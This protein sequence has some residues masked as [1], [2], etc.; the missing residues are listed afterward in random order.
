M[1]LQIIKGQGPSL[2]GRNWLRKIKLNWCSIKKISCDLQLDNVL[3]KHQSVFKDELGT[4]Q[5][6]MAKLFVK[7]DSMPIFFKP[8]PVPHALK[9]AFEQELDRL[10]GMGVIEKVRYSEWAAPIV[11]VVKPDNLIKVC[12]HCKVNVNS[13]LEVDQHPLPNLKELFVTL[14]GGEKYSKLDLSEAYQQIL[15]DEDSREFVTINTHKGLYRPTRLSFGVSSAS[16]IFQSKYSK[17]YPW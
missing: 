5:G 8:R 7:P 12:G 11:P 14:S 4:T 9:G 2:F 17:A 13:V 3:A 1:P 6:V 10:E 15:L 16:A